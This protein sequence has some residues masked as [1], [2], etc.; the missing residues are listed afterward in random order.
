MSKVSYKVNLFV[1][2]NLY[3]IFNLLICIIA[4]NQVVAKLLVTL[5]IHFKIY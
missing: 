4:Y 3:L 5:P 1:L 2:V